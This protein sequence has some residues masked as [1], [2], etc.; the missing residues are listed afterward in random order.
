MQHAYPLSSKVFWISSRW[1]WWCRWS[2]RNWPRICNR[3]RRIETRTLSCWRISARSVLWSTICR[4]RCRRWSAV[5]WKHPQDLL[6]ASWAS[7]ATTALWAASSAP[8]AAFGSPARS[9]SRDSSY[10]S[11]SSSSLPRPSR[12]TARTT[13]TTERLSTPRSATWRAKT[14]WPQS[15]VAQFRCDLVVLA[16]LIIAFYENVPRPGVPR[17]HSRNLLYSS[18]LLLALLAPRVSPTRSHHF[19]LSRSR[20]LHVSTR[21]PIL[22]VANT[23]ARENQRVDCG[24]RPNQ[25]FMEVVTTDG[26]RDERYC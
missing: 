14:Q 17:S 25:W 20:V 4:T 7:W 1:W 9:S 10:S 23:Y 3:A 19:V 15:Q 12:P 22:Y 16:T 18:Y 11:C 8:A 2:R 13:G 6:W 26:W 24:C 5:P 21:S